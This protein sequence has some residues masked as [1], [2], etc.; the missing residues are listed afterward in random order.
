VA[1][2]NTGDVPVTIKV[3]AYS[4]AGDGA[5]TVV[6]PAV[7]LPPWGW[8][9]YNRVLRGPGYATGWV[10]AE[11]VSTAGAFGS[12]GVINDNVTNDGSFI[13]AVAADV[14][15]AFMNVPVLVE[16]PTF[17]SELVLTNASASPAVFTMTFTE[18]LAAGTGSSTRTALAPAPI[19]ITLPPMT[20]TIRS[21]AV[22]WLRGLGAT[23]GAKNAASYAGSLHITVSGASILETN[24]GSRSAAVSPAGGQYGFYSPARLPG[25]EA[26]DVGGIYGLSANANNR[27]NLAV[28]NRAAT[29]AGGSITVRAFAYDGDAGG[30]ASVGS[31]DFVLGAGQWMQMNDFLTTFGIQNGYVRLQLVSGLAPWDAY[32]IIN[33]GRSPGQRTGD[34]V[35]LPISTRYTY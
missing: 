23:V 11:R 14:P 17:R 30:T 4:G 31:R 33:D 12:Y 35:F 18:S 20:V 24:A 28:M 1:I 34:S 6:D 15:P 27:T 5:A 8:Q 10:V 25:D 7:V 29:S 13:P 21:E 22:D 9:Q 16:T 3:T 32:A 26:F 2:Y 19:Q